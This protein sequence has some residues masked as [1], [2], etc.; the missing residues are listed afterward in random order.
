M[1]FC[2]LASGSKGNM[3]YI[4]TEDTKIL[5]DAG[6]SYRQAKAKL[7][8]INVDINDVDILLITH[9]HC[10]HIGPKG[11]NLEMIIRHTNAALYIN[12]S[13]FNA[14]DIDL[15]TRLIGRKLKFIDSDTKYSFQ[16]TTIY[17]LQL[18]HDTKN[19]L[20]FIISSNDKLL[21]YIADTGI[22]Q[23]E[24]FNL[25]RVC[26]GIIIEANHNIEMLSNSG[27]DPRLIR[28]ILS[29]KGHLSNYITF[30]ILKNII[31]N[32]QQ[33]IVLAHKSDECNSLECLIEEIIEPIKK[34][35]QGKILVAEQN[36]ITEFME[37]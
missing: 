34:I 6:I 23:T 15:R 35:Y 1:K 28:R 24:Y 12:E 14:L 3:T 20:G 17:T 5:I 13:S 30:N 36:E 37:I 22:V 26:Q 7:A 31:S 29:P 10:D 9:E 16:N 18:V 4:E 19:C 32:R 8:M 21:A 33:C 11:A 25:L 27:R 2:V